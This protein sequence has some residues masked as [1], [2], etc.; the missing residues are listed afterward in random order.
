MD[1]TNVY[2]VSM[3]TPSFTGTIWICADNFNSVMDKVSEYIRLK[4]HTYTR[5]CK[6]LSIKLIHE[7]VVI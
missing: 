1:I 2:E 7:K 3:D 4:L 6:I 5:N